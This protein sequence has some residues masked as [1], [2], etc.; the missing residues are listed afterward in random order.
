MSSRAW[1]LFAAVSVLWG[2]PYLFIKIAVDGGMP[3]VVLA[4]G[5]IV[6]GAVVLLALAHRAN[7]IGQI[8]GHLKAL[9]GYAV[10]E[11]CIPF[12]LIAAGEQ[13]VSSSL[14][15]IIVASAPLNVAILALRFD[16]EERTTGVRLVGLIVGLV[17]IAL[18]VGLDATGSAAEIL[19]ALG[20]LVAAFGY[21][22]GPMI[23]KRQLGGL[24][25]RVA[26]GASLAI[27]AVVLTVPAILELP[28]SPPSGGAFA[29]MI[30][31]GLICTALAFVLMTLL[32]REIGPARSLVITYINPVVAVILGVLL[33]SEHPGASA[34]GGLVLILAGS[35]L[36]TR[37]GRREIPATGSAGP[38]AATTTARTPPADEEL[39]HVGLPDNH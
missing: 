18:L 19:G 25:A 12:P 33:L 31:L 9:I 16:A 15:A 32:V 34:I 24:D 20:I 8:R 39:V 1:T 35:W 22:A 37:P 27:A 6:M 2:I 17:G 21:A 11:V 28:S 7:V 30:V 36:A 26:M 5:R 4:W 13:H 14:A 29:S 3:P 10:L 23:L 38:V